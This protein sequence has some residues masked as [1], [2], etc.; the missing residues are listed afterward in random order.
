VVGIHNSP[1]LV[2]SAGWWTPTVVSRGARFSL[3]GVTFDAQQ[4][5]IRASERID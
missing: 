1:G 2:A 3:Q 4:T 5:K